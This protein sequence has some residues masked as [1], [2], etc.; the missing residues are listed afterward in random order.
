M[1]TC[2]RH[3]HR[4]CW[5]SNEIPSESGMLP[6]KSRRTRRHRRVGIVSGRLVACLL[7]KGPPIAGR[8][9][10][11]SG[12]SKKG[13]RNSPSLRSNAL[14]Y[15]DQKWGNRNHQMTRVHFTT[16]SHGRT[17]SRGHDTSPPQPLLL[18]SSASFG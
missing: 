9:L 10:L 2:M 4:V 6:P 16:Q 15:C 17:L 8:A 18:I 12:K 7:V 11:Q 14:Q 3:F 13:N 1:T 5:T